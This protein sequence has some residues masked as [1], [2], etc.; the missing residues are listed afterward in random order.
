M[1]RKM[2]VKM[3]VATAIFAA[4]AGCSVIQGK[5]GSKLYGEDNARAHAA[6]LDCR[7]ADAV[8]AADAAIK[9]GN[10]RFASTGYLYKGAALKE[11]GQLAELKSVYAVLLTLD[12]GQ[13]SSHA[14]TAVDKVLMNARDQRAEKNGAA[15][16]KGLPPLPTATPA[17]TATAVPGTTP[18]PVATPIPTVAPTPVKAAAKKTTK[19][20]KATKPAVQAA[21]K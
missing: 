5:Y 4:M 10:K 7:H 14:E 6:L 18:V 20:T 15:D 8:A 9:S 3:T 1:S 2:I 17:P 12:G 11:T 21:A 13:A 19:T 16:C